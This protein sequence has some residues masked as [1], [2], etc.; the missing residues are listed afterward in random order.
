MSGK[1]PQVK[2]WSSP[3]RDALALSFP[4][5]RPVPCIFEY[6]YFA[7]P[8]SDLFGRVVFPVSRPWGA[9]WRRNSPWPR[10]PWCPCRLGTGAA[11]GYSEESGIPSC[12][13]HQEPLRGPDLHR[14]APVM[15]DISVRLKL[16]T[17][18]ALLR[19]SAWSLWTT[20]WSGAPPPE[21]RPP[22]PRG[23]RLGSAHPPVQ[24]AHREPLRLR[25]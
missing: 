15:R 22:R 7:R 12:G 5:A 2:W 13:P 16:N 3:R 18:P 25:H 17:V 11:M 23:R 4:K 21:N 19:A 20:L 9:P 8:D 1:S 10:M 14:A 6:V 24:P